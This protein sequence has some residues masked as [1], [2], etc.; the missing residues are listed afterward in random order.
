MSNIFR[1]GA[2]TVLQQN[3]VFLSK[4][5]Q[6]YISTTAP[7]FSGH[8]APPPPGLKPV[9]YRG[10]KIYPASRKDKIGAWF[11]GTCMWL[12]VMI[13]AYHD[14]AELIGLE[15]P[16]W[17]IPTGESSDDDEWFELDDDDEPMDINEIYK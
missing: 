15:K 5:T 13:R 12:W 9:E 3:R 16:H 8:G 7:K 14:G 6:R 17:Q 2:R 10:V 11:L 1:L 4:G